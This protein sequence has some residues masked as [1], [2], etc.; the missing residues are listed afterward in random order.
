MMPFYLSQ[1]DHWIEHAFYAFL[2][3][4][5]LWLKRQKLPDCQVVQAIMGYGSEFLDRVKDRRVLKVVDCQNSHPTTYYGYWQRECDIWNPGEKVPI[6]RSMF[7]RMNRELQLAD[8]LL[9]PSVFVRDT[10]LLNGIPEEKCVLVPFGVD[11]SI[12]KPRQNVPK[13]PRFINIGGIGLRKGHQY[14]FRAFH[15]VK[16][17]IPE[18]ELICVGLYKHDIAMS[19]E[20]GK[21]LFDTKRAFHIRNW[22]S[23]YRPAPLWFCHRWKRDLRAS[24]LSLWPQGYL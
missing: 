14:L 15:E 23:F 6:P 20:D 18:A 9:C 4:W 13:V 5:K 19:V 7:A 21:V 17:R 1:K 2:P 3:V 16:K 11:I 24:F 12:F 10:M 8:L 22:R